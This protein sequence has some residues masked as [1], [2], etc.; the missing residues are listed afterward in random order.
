MT[1][2]T[3]NK[4]SITAWRQLRNMVIYWLVA[5]AKLKPHQV[6]RLY[7]SDFYT[8]S[9]APW[10]V[11]AMPRR[12]VRSGPQFTMLVPTWVRMTLRVLYPQRPLFTTCQYL[13]ST[14]PD[15]QALTGGH[16]GR[17]ARRLSNDE[18]YPGKTLVKGLLHV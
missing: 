7:Y 13:F 14:K 11:F 9:G 4:L 10:T 3:N 2:E 15:F 16:V 12:M 8:Q 17:I 6:A 18:C 1:N 5:E